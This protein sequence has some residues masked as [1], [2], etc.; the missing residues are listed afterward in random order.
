M[1]KYNYT[2]KM[3]FLSFTHPKVVTKQLLV[4]TDFDSMGKIFIEIK[5]FRV[6]NNFRVSNILGEL[7]L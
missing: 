2:P 6:H 4:D 1:P 3:K 7:S 5:G